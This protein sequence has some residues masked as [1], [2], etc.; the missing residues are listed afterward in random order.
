MRQWVPTGFLVGVSTHSLEQ[1][2]KAEAE[3]SNYIV[4]G[5]VFETPS[6]L[7]YGPPLGIGVLRRI[8][9]M[10]RLPVFG[11]GGITRDTIQLVLDAG[12]AGVAAIRLFQQGPELDLTKVPDF[13]SAH[14]AGFRKDRGA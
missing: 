3:H 10:V 13:P 12:A 11:I 1:A 4:L 5:P 14:N 8:C 9:R 6:K 7:Q 2:R